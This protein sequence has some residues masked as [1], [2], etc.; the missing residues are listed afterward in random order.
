MTTIF[1]K[2]D[3]KIKEVLDKIENIKEDAKEEIIHTRVEE[4][5][6]GKRWNEKLEG[7]LKIWFA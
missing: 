7:I 4:L 1:E 3:K 6:R 5:Y 2:T